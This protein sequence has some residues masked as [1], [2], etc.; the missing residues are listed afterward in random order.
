MYLSGLQEIDH[1]LP[2]KRAEESHNFVAPARAIGRG[3][4]NANRITAGRIYV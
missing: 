3:Q 2:V 1:I 4:G